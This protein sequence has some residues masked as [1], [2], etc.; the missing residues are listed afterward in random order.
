[1]EKNNLIKINTLMDFMSFLRNETISHSNID[2]A[3]Y[4][5]EDLKVI[6][7]NQKKIPIYRKMPEL[8]GVRFIEDMK[9]L[10]TISGKYIPI[11]DMETRKLLFTQDDFLNYRRKMSGLKEYN[12]G[13]YIFSDNLYFDELDYYLELIDKNIQDVK[14]QLQ[15]IVSEFTKIMNTIG[16]SV[17]LGCNSGGDVELVETGSTSRYTNIPL[18]GVDKKYD[19]D[20]TVR[21][22]PDKVWLVKDALREQ[23]NFGGYITT[24][25]YKLRLTDVVIGGLDKPVDLD[26]SL[27]PQKEKYLSTEQALS[28]RLLNMKEQDEE[29]YRLVLAN[30]MY[31]KDMLKRAGAYKPSRSILDGSSEYGGLGGI[32]IENWI[33]QHGGSLIDASEDFLTHAEGKEFIEFEKEYAIMDFGQDHVS[34]SKKEFPFHN[35][36]MRNMRYKGYEKMKE[37]LIDF[38]S[39]I[40][41][42]NNHKWKYNRK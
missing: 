37:C 12:T 16:L 42:N 28:E 38:K 33:L 9:L 27:T 17:T 29:K 39:K 26:F 35:F 24:V 22:S 25:R 18:T 34:T 4:Y 20:F 36:V 40:N 5:I 13:N 15:P 21:V 1:V 41:F 31:T 30:I 32:G 7:L 6:I 3:I 2:S 8:T 10:E 23:L 11:F 19:F 14:I